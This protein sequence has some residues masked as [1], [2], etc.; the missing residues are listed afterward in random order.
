MWGA[1][2][3]AGTGLAGPFNPSVGFD[4]ADIA[5][6]AGLISKTAPAQDVSVTAAKAPGQA[7]ARA[8]LLPGA[9]APSIPA[10]VIQARARAGLLPGATAPS[11][12][13]K[14]ISLDDIEAGLGEPT[15]VAAFQTRA[16]MGDKTA[17]GFDAAD[18]FGQATAKTISAGPMADLDT[19]DT[20]YAAPMAAPMS[21]AHAQPH[22]LGAADMGMGAPDDR[23]PGKQG[24]MAAMSG[25]DMGYSV[26]PPAPSGPAD[27]DNALHAKRADVGSQNNTGMQVIGQRPA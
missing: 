4:P 18:P 8:D 17:F 11:I 14:V 26:Q 7:R 23:D 2:K 21:L 6:R 5:K 25:V 24:P 27:I 9:T 13:A 10:Q 16:R 3:A 20:S 19:M 15:S 1:K 12:P 22:T